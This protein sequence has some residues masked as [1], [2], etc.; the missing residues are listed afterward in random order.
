TFDQDGGSTEGPGY[1]SFGFGYYTVVADLVEL[2][3]GGRARFL[4]GEPVARI[5]R[6]PLR[7]LLAPG[8]YAN[9]SDCDRDV[10]LVAPLLAFL[11][12]R[13]DI[14]ENMGL[15]AQ[16]GP[17]AREGLTWGLRELFWAPDHDA[18]APVPARHDFF[19]G[20]HWL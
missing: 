5:A 4:D 14:R 12:R 18:P 7:T 10:R 9:F 2:R 15:A 11:A 6:F 8:A 16:E 13:L 19:R 17:A 20:M 1:W 3:T